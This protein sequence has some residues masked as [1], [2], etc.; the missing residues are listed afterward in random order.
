MI[1]SL[2]YLWRDHKRYNY[3][4]LIFNPFFLLQLQHCVILWKKW[5]ER[6]TKAQT[7]NQPASFIIFLGIL[8]SH[9]TYFSPIAKC[10]YKVVT[11]FFGDLRKI[12]SLCSNPLT[13]QQTSNNLHLHWKKQEKIT[14]FWGYKKLVEVD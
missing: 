5:R 7:D 13:C 2:L 3:V 11:V 10:V 12:V 6:K 1:A 8:F 4:F 9:P 14:I